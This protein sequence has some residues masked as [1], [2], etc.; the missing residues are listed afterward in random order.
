MTIRL[1]RNACKIADGWADHFSS[2]RPQR[3]TI[4]NAIIH[5]YSFQADHICSGVIDFAYDRLPYPTSGEYKLGTG[6]EASLTA[7][8]NHVKQKNLKLSFE[9]KHED[10]ANHLILLSG[11]EREKCWRSLRDF[12]LTDIKD[13]P[14]QI[15]LELSEEELL[16]ARKRSLTTIDLA[17]R[18]DA[19]VA[20]ASD[21]EL[22]QIAES[23]S[24]VG[25]RLMRIRLVLLTVDETTKMR[26][27]DAIESEF[28]NRVASLLRHH[29][30][31]D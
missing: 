24:Q 9:L 20:K 4:L 12:V 23:S 1:T 15:Y 22:R 7:L 5:I 18:L 13:D 14:R 6:A 26:L 16:D 25:P 28:E 27:S 19:F 21:S 10:L 29:L 30:L 11:K 8:H 17:Q 31:I 2:R 3:K